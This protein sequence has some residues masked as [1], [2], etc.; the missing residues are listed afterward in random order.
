[1][2]VYSYFQKHFKPLLVD[3]F[4]TLQVNYTKLH[5][6]L[7]EEPTVLNEVYNILKYIDQLCEYNW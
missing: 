6:K 7:N 4:W 3:L 2:S 5:S 1:M